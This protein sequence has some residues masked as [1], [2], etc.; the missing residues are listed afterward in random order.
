[1]QIDLKQKAV[2][3]AFLVG[4]LV[5]LAEVLFFVFNPHFPIPDA[6]GLLLLCLNPPS[7]LFGVFIDY[8]PT[9]VELVI[10]FALVVVLNAL[11]YAAVAALFLR[12]RE[13]MRDP[14]RSTKRA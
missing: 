6:L 2:R 1:M 5:A 12:L 3:T 13:R 4:A 10:P 14:A 11:L 7:F 9:T 8:Q